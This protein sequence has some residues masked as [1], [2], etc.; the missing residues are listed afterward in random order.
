VATT[1]QTWFAAMILVLGQ[2]VTRELD[3]HPLAGAARR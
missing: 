3:L 2:A 1:P